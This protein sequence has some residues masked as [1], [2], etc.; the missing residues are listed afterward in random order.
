M[1]NM[2]DNRPLL[3]VKNLSVDFR[4]DRKTV[5]HAV[6]D[7]SFTV[8]SGETLGIQG[9]SFSKEKTCSNFRQRKCSISAETG[10]P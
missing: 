9:K 4:I 1:T 5:L 6:R 8:N 2:T 10:Y 7:V 3:E